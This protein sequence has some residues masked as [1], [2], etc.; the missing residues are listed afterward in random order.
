MSSLIITDGPSMHEVA[1]S[2]LYRFDKRQSFEV[3][4]KAHWD[5]SSLITTLPVDA[6]VVA[7]AY[8]SG[9]TGMF[10]IEV[11]ARI[12]HGDAFRVTG[13]Y[14]A[15]TRKGSLDDIGTINWVRK[16]EHPAHV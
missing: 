11:D 12:G 6:K 13:F 7:L 1:L 4:F 3:H 10:L 2:F 5:D 15:S 9:T 16:N 8:E 14:N